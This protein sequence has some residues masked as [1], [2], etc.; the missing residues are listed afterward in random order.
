MASKAAVELC[1]KRQK[2]T[3]KHAFRRHPPISNTSAT[4]IHRQTFRGRNHSTI[5][6]DETPVEDKD[7]DDSRMESRICIESSEETT[8]T[9]GITSSM[10]SFYR[11]TDGSIA[12]DGSSRNRLYQT[13][14]AQMERMK[15]YMCNSLSSQQ[16]NYELV[17]CLES[18][19][20]E[21][22]TSV[23]VIIK[24]WKQHGYE[25]WWFY[26]LDCENPVHLSAPEVDKLNDV[27]D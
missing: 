6:M 27:F 15:T 18:I 24:A 19:A 20:A 7:M 21:H 11:H 26:D 16:K 5:F 14:P 12:C 9:T 17:K 13:S 25:N 10:S 2:I 1:H 3:M 8:V 22:S 4:M 23:P